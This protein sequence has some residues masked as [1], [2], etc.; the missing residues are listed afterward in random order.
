MCSRPVARIESGEVWNPPKVDLLDPKG[1]LFQPHPPPPKKKKSLT[2]TPF[3]PTMFNDKLQT[4][5]KTS[6][7]LQFWQLAGAECVGNSLFN[8]VPVLADAYICRR[9]LVW[10]AQWHKITMIYA[11]L[12]WGFCPGWAVQCESD[13]YVPTGERKQGHSVKAFIEKGGHWVWD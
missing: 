10:F 5:S 6:L 2:K 7:C 8:L 13:G 9:Q 4:C 1:G 11:N 3:W 12:W